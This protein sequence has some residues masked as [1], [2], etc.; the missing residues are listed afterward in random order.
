[1]FIARMARDR[2]VHTLM[3]FMADDLGYEIRVVTVEEKQAKAVE[4]FQRCKAQV[5]DM[6]RA[7]G[8]KVAE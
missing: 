4:D 3:K 2:G 8:L 1:M 5:A 7:F 6:A